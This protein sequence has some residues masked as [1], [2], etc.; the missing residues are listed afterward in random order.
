MLS[1]D[2]I[3]GKEDFLMMNASKKRIIAMI[4][5]G[6]M[7]REL[8]WSS[9]TSFA[10]G[11][12]SAIIAVSSFAASFKTIAPMISGLKAPA[13]LLQRPIILILFAALS[14]GPTML[15]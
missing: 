5:Y 13:I 14:I 2:S 11:S 6:L 15:I 9:N 4:I 8:S 12:F 10:T 7:I 3:S 1:S